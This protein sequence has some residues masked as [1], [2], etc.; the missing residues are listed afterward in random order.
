LRNYALAE[1]AFPQ[2]STA[3]QWFNEA[4]FE[5]YRKLGYLIGRNLIENPFEDESTFAS[6]LK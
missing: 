2:Q 4:Q 6:F 3:D 5:S 1:P